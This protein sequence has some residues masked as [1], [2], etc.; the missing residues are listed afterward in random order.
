MMYVVD[1]SVVAEFLILGTYTTHTQAFFMG[2]LH[3]D[4][5]TVPELALNGNQRYRRVARQL[6]GR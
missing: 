1:A 6:S 5:F 3:N 2:A 4:I